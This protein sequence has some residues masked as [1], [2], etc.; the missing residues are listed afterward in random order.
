M[1]ATIEGI[2]RSKM[3]G[4]IVLE[5]GS[6][7]VE[8][9][10]PEKLIFSLGSEG[11]L[12]RLF[13][14]MHVREDAI[15]LFGFRTESEKRMFLAL[16]GVSGIGPRVAMGIISASG[17]SEIAS[18]ITGEDTASLTRFPGVGK[19]TAERIVLELKDRLE[20][21]DYGVEDVPGAPALDSEM[22]D[23]A[24]SALCS[25]GFSRKRAAEAV[26]ELG[27]DDI[28][29]SMEVGDLVREVLR[30]YPPGGVK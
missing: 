20:L 18:Y 9:F 5:T 10:V 16:M 8:V 22:L 14:Y 21:S 29:D 15:T 7:G 1:I 17:A 3:K 12:V 27:P 19:K 24:V 11:E 23:D 13:T 2:L 6:F 30:R 25:L 26:K 4:S 28:E